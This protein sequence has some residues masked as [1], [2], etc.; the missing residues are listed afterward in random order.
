VVSRSSFDGLGEVARLVRR[1]RLNELELLRFKPVGRGA[2]LD[3]ELTPDQ[4][5]R[6][7]PLA[8][9]LML[10]HRIR[11]KLDCS[12]APMVFWHRPSARAA[13]FWG[14]QGCVAGDVLAA[15]APE[16]HLMGC[17]FAG[18][19]EADARIPGAVREA[20]RQGFASFR[21][22]AASAPEPCKSCEY[23]RLCRGGCRAVAAAHG[24]FSAPDPG[25]PRVQEWTART[26]EHP[27]G[28]GSF[29]LPVV[30][31]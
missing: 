18:P 16:G 23:L 31:G 24:E 17:S 3:E 11:V 12:F 1:L 27:V 6:I 2:R 8:R 20:W 25:C 30:R 5:R 10:R 22:F 14:V 28:A 4:A 26:A 7:Y 9:R 21:G 19:P 29:A 13:A 15:V